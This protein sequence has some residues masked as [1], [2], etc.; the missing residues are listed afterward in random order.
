[1]KNDIFLN[2]APPMFEPTKKPT[3]PEKL[4]DI[5]LRKDDPQLAAA[6]RSLAPEDH[7]D[8]SQVPLLPG[9]RLFA[10]TRKYDESP[11]PIIDPAPAKRL[12]D[13]ENQ[14]I[15]KLLPPGYNPCLDC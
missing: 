10:S 2:Q 3:Q 12:Q 4:E 8:I 1:M 9:D 5:L 15:K 6:I 13:R 7:N 14:E 11:A